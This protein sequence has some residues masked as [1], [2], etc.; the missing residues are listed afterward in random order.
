MPTDREG[1]EDDEP[2]TDNEAKEVADFDREMAAVG[3]SDINAVEEE[4]EDTLLDVVAL[5]ER[6]LLNE[7]SEVWVLETTAE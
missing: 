5:T 6:L 2:N 4:D 3:E 1:R 7:L